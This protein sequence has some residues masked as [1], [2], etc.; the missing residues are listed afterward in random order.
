MMTIKIIFPIIV[1]VA[2]TCLN[3]NVSASAED[4]IEKFTEISKQME[5]NFKRIVD[6][7]TA[8]V[9]YL[10]R[11]KKPFDQKE[12]DNANELLDDL[13]AKDRKSREDY[14]AKNGR[15][16]LVD[17]ATFNK[18]L[19]ESR[20][21]VFAVLTATEQSS[22]TSY[23]YKTGK[24]R[25]EELLFNDVRPLSEIADLLQKEPDSIK[26]Q[27]NYSVNDKTYQSLWACGT[28]P[29]VKRT[30]GR[31][32]FTATV[33]LD[34]LQSDDMRMQSEVG[35]V[36][37]SEP[38]VLL[39]LKFGSDFIPPSSVKALEKVSK[40]PV[41]ITESTKEGKKIV[42][43]LFGKMGKN[44]ICYEM[45]LYSER[46]YAIQSMKLYY[47]N[48]VSI[49]YEFSQYFEAKPN[50]WIPKHIVLKNRVLG[51]DVEHAFFEVE[52]LSIEPL[53]LG[54]DLDDKLFEINLTR[55]E[56]A[57]LEKTDKINIRRKFFEIPEELRQQ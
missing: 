13:D 56:K 47:N 3:S 55:Q 6:Y 15:D 16:R 1:F 21:R 19:A 33:I 26:G 35:L 46:N 53:N 38:D 11:E 7:K 30:E 43:C 27:I 49:D 45:N 5:E 14:I 54:L 23:Y 42:Q 22:L 9:V 18:H 17:D 44:E 34:R 36:V 10:V 41:S 8:K 24:V 29:A 4:A 52:F 57:E 51:E 31:G 50:L 2:C 39:F 48:L 40:L 20:S 32:E 25:R 12:V 28:H 37:N